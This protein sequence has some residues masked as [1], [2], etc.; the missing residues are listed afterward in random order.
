MKLKCVHYPQHGIL[1]LIIV[2]RVPH[3]LL[4][5]LALMYI[6]QPV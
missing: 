2:L 1:P 5:F 6:T 3:S 4:Y